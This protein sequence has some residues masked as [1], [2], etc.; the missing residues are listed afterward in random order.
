MNDP[1]VI[2]LDQGIEKSDRK[3]NYRVAFVFKA[4]IEKS[5]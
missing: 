2:D 4:N 1:N 5:I 3:R